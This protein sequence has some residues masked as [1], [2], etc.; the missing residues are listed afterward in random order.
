M[1]GPA[2]TIT[3]LVAVHDDH[4]YL[5]NCLHHLIRNG[6]QYA[7]VDNSLGDSVALILDD[8]RIKQNLRAVVRLAHT[9]RFVLKEQLATKQELAE[10]IESDW[11]LHVDVDEVMHSCR[12]GETLAQAIARLDAHGFNVINFDE[13]VFLPVEV[14]YDPEICVYQAMRH[15]YFFEPFSPRLMR[16]WKRMPSLSNVPSGGHVLVGDKLKLAEES[17]ALRHYIFRDQRHAYQKYLRRRYSDE[18]LAMG[19]HLNHV[20]FAEGNFTFPDISLLESLAAPGGR[21][22]VKSS[23]HRKHYWE[24]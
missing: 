10:S 6:I 14:D 1:S 23:P 5:P 24:W 12:P 16:A 9:G 11:F 21:N 22:L 15:Y 13:F 20:G 3:A 4:A 7:V 19:W 17:L 18:E 2:I 8:S